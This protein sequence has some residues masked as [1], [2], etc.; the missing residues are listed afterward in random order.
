MCWVL[1]PSSGSTGTLYTLSHSAIWVGRL[2]HCDQSLSVFP[3]KWPTGTGQYGPT[4][5]PTFLKSISRASPAPEPELRPTSDMRTDSGPRDREQ[6]QC[7]V[8]Y[9]A[10]FYVI[11]FLYPAHPEK[12]QDFQMTHVTLM[13]CN[14]CN[15]FEIKITYIYFL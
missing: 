5:R 4:N 12:S 2:Q 9:N 1:A 7:R 14:S 3:A 13:I 8:H 6:W 15:T 10:R 11:A